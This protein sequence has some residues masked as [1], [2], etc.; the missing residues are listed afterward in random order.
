MMMNLQ[1]LQMAGYHVSESKRFNCRCCALELELE[2][3]Q[4]VAFDCLMGLR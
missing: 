4:C 1:A 3:S 2:E